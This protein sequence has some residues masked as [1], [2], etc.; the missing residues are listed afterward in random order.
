MLPNASEDQRQLAIKMWKAEDAEPPFMDGLAALTYLAI[1]QEVLWVPRLFGA[2][3]WLIGGIAVYLLAKEFTSHDAAVISTGI[4]L[5]LPFGVIASRT[6]QPDPLMIAFMLFAWWLMYRWVKKPS[7][8]LSILAGI[9]AGLSIL[10]KG[11]MV[12]YALAGFGGI[13]TTRGFKN[14]VRDLRFWVMGSLSVIP[15]FIFIFYLDFIV[16]TLTNQL[17]LRVFPNLLILPTFYLQWKGM[18]E[19]VVGLGL[20]VL[21]WVGIFLFKDRQKRWFVISFWAGYLGYGLFFA[22][23]YQSHNYYHLP[24]IPIVAL[25]IAPSTSSPGSRTASSSSRSAGRWSG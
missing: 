24:L 5:F 16:R 25:S 12:F 18:V 23:Y 15:T 20:F 19:E 2:L 22:Y 9:L 14:C 4:Y 1:G 21:A 17:T 11:V 3:F 6:F 7:W 13:L 10:A 8:K